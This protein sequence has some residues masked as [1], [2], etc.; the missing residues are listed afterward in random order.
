[1][2]T[3]LTQIPS[4]SD[5]YGPNMSLQTTSQDNSKTVAIV[6]VFSVIAAASIII[7]QQRQNNK[8]LTNRLNAEYNRR[9]LCKLNQKTL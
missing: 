7:Y 6:V 4:F 8:E 5:L 1:M 9:M 3:H 2:V